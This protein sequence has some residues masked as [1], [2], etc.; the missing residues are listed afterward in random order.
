MPLKI[1]IISLIMLT[2][3]FAHARTGDTQGKVSAVIVDHNTNRTFN[4]FIVYFS[5]MDNDRW[6]CITNDGYIR[7]K[8]NGTGVDTVNYKQLFS[9][10]LAAQVSGKKLALD[11]NGTNPCG[12]VNTAWMVN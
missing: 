12:N 11:S 9:V 3:S 7:V 6:Q 8:S 2:S 1:L 5:A 4:S 10:A